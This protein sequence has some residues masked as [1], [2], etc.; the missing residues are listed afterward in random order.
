L[1]KSITFGRSLRRI[2]AVPGRSLNGVAHFSRSLS[3]T[4]PVLG[5]RLSGMGSNISFSRR[6]SER[7]QWGADS[8]GEKANS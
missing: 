6:L 3:R 5:R 2:T 8:S 4:A 1:E 7:E